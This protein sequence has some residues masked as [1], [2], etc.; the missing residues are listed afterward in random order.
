VGGVKA[1]FVGIANPNNRR[2][3]ARPRLWKDQPITGN[4]LA[5]QPEVEPGNANQQ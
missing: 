1:R 2:R 5:L 4:E 3:T